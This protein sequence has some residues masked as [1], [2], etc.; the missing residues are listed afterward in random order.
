TALRTHVL[1]CDG[2][3]DKR[4]N[5]MKIQKISHPN[6][7]EQKNESDG[8]DSAAPVI[9]TSNSNNIDEASFEGA[10]PVTHPVQD[11]EPQN[12]LI[13][14]TTYNAVPM[15]SVLDSDLVDMA[16]KDFYFW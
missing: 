4:E 13:P 9:M 2:A 5:T 7:N 11:S 14:F 6:S 3:V 15:L 8:L 10:H 1:R 16:F 12:Q